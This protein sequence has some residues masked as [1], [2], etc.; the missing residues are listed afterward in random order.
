[1]FGR[2]KT[3]PKYGG[4]ALSAAVIDA[5]KATYDHKRNQ[6]KKDFQFNLERGIKI[7]AVIAV[8]VLFIVLVVTNYC[9]KNYDEASKNLWSGITA[10]VG[11]TIGKVTKSED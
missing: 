3:K 5:Q 6:A 4:R 10:L 7:G 8:P 9:S 1:M 2:K 11:Y